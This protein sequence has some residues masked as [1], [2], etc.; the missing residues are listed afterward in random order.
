MVFNDSLLSIPLNA[1]SLCSIVTTYFRF[2]LIDIII[3]QFTT[4]AILKESHLRLINSLILILIS[5][6]EENLRIKPLGNLIWYCMEKLVRYLLFDLRFLYL[7]LTSSIC[8][9][10]NKCILLLYCIT[11]YTIC[12]ILT[13]ILRNSA[14][15]R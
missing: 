11:T 9:D 13:S 2:L 5:T 12:I 14:R 3:C 1:Y 7:F 4:D 6:L 8:K 15:H 10:V